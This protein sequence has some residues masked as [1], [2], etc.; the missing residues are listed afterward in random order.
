MCPRNSR[1][2]AGTARTT[3][4]RLPH[5]DEWQSWAC[6]AQATALVERREIQILRLNADDRPIHFRDSSCLRVFSSSAAAASTRRAQDGQRKILS[7]NGT[8]RSPVS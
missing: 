8:K 7:A 1:W 5:P 3:D 2:D 4:S 6:L